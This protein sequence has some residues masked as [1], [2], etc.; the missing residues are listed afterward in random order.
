ME[1]KARESH[2]GKEYAQKQ[3]NEL[4]EIHTQEMRELER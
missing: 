1:N 4:K 3:V 2:D